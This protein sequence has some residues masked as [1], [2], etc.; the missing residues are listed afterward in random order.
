MGSLIYTLGKFPHLYQ[1][2]RR[3]HSLIENAVEESLRLSPPF[4]LFRKIVIRDYR[5]HSGKELK[6]GLTIFPIFKYNRS[7]KHFENPDVFDIHRSPKNNRILTFGHGIHM[8]VGRELARLEARI[9]LKQILSRFEEI[10]LYPT[11]P[12]QWRNSPLLVAAQSLT[13][14]MKPVQQQ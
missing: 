10:T 1:E 6:K 5:C 2:L 7:P 9:A 3:D 12:I 4:P 14:K 13:L 11:D 8:C